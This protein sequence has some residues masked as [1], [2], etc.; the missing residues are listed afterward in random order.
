M[1]KIVPPVLFLICLALMVLLRW[2]WPLRVVLPFPYN[3]L[4]IVP[5]IAGILSGLL[6]IRQFLKVHTNILPFRDADKLV[7]QGPYHLTRNPMYLGLALALLG[8]W[9][10][11]GALTPLIGIVIFIVV[12]DRWYIRFEERMLRQKFGPAFE[13][14]CASTRRWI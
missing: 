13:D 4:G 5:I 7:T 1:K 6:G 10:L 2:L 8:A 12:A 11:L 14:F 3:L 9:A